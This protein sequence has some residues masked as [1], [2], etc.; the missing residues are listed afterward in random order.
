M[1]TDSG[2]NIDEIFDAMDQNNDEQI[3]VDEVVAYYKNLPKT[4]E[5]VA[6]F[7]NVMANKD[8]SNKG[9]FDLHFLFKTLMELW[10]KFGL[11]Q[12]FS[13]I[14]CLLTHSAIC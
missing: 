13:S 14:M 9:K 12:S 7:A 6:Y 10:H 8:F 2:R 4:R 1:G 5:S 3:S 11:W